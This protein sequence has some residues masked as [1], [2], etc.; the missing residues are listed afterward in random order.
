MVDEHDSDADTIRMSSPKFWD[1][2]NVDNLSVMPNSLK[3][4]ESTPDSTYVNYPGYQR[5]DCTYI[6]H[7]PET[8]CV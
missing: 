1:G 3:L 2:A 8:T 6:F 4:T 7:Y 5:F